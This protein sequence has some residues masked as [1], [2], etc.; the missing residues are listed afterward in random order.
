MPQVS[1]KETIPMTREAFDMI[2]DTRLYW[3]GGSGFLL[4]VRGTIILIDPVLV[5]LPGEKRCETGLPMLVDFPIS[6]YDVPRV[7]LLLFSHADSDHLGPVTTPILMKHDPLVIGSVFVRDTVQKL[8][9]KKPRALAA[10]AGAELSVAN[11]EIKLTP[12]DHSWQL[13]NPA[14]YETIYGP[15]DCLGFQITTPD[16]TFFFMGDTRLMKEHLAIS[17]VDVFALDVSRCK[18]HLGIDG[19][20]VMANSLKDALLI[21]YHY[22]TYDRPQV[23][24][25]S[26][27]PQEVLPKVIDGEKR[28]RIMAP[29][30]CL[31]MSEGKEKQQEEKL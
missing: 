12:C 23:D 24:A 31:I 18:Y 30:E 15:D 2:P 20:S 3:L 9:G 1:A 26:G 25:H 19:S 21:P 13:C 29:G 27:D 4:N 11:V 8:T 6:A 16:G 14:R 7:D 17:G 5:T 28:A 22:G 10:K